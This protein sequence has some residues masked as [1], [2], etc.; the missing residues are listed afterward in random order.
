MLVRHGSELR[1]RRFEGDPGIVVQTV[2]MLPRQG[3]PRHRG[4]A[5]LRGAVAGPAELSGGPSPGVS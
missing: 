4:D 1:L 3:S 5:T 2:C